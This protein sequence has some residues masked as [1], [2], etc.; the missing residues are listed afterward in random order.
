VIVARWLGECRRRG[1]PAWLSTTASSAVRLCL[2]ARE[3]GIDIS[4]TFFRGSGEPLSAGKM[5]VIADA[6]CTARCHYAMAEIGRMGVAC[7]HPS[8]YD[9]VHVVSDKMAFLQHEIQMAGGARVPALIATTLHR[10]VPKVMLNV[11]LGDYATM[12]RRHCGC[13]WEAMGFT[14][15]LSTIRSYEKLTSEGMHFVGADLIALVDE[16]LPGRFGGSPTDYQFVEEEHDGLPSV[17]LVVSKRVGPLS[18]GE[19][20]TTV[21]NALASRDAACRMMAGL[22]RDGNTLRVVRREPHS[23]HAGK[24]LALHVD[25]RKAAAS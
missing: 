15:Q 20:Q 17:A 19:V 10:G 2:A 22:W 25:R 12:G 18:P 13:L 8:T 9:D 21:L 5:R 14:Q 3:H 11:E 7:R 16:V 1:R 4:G 23:T 6:G 24:I